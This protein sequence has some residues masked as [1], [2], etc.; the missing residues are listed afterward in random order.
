MRQTRVS[1]LVRIARTVA[2]ALT[3][4]AA[5]TLVAPL[6]A[7]TPFVPLEVVWI[8]ISPEKDT[9]RIS[10][11]ELPKS[12][13][14]GFSP[15]RSPIHTFPT[16]RSRRASAEATS[17]TITIASA[18][19]DRATA[20]V[21][22]ARNTSMM[23]TAPR[24]WPADVVRDSIMIEGDEV[25]PAVRVGTASLPSP[26]P[27]P[28]LVRSS[29]CLLPPWAIYVPRTPNGALGKQRRR[30]KA[31]ASGG[32]RALRG[33][34]APRPARHPTSPALRRHLYPAWKSRACPARRTRRDVRHG[35]AYVPP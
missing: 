35:D 1:P 6:A 2:A 14:V 30:F 15:R 8:T 31:G 10:C 18:P 34:R 23:T 17:S 32:G 3:S 16:P 26:S 7:I 19:L 5:Y 4:D 13:P 20:A 22:K 27:V 21:V 29:E 25:I 11:G 12:N 24:A 9:P 33:V 28:T